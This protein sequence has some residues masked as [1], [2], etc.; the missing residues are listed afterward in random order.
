MDQPKATG[1]AK[2]Q[3][4]AGGAG[5]RCAFRFPRRRRILRTADFDRVMK[6]GV[7]MSDERLTV[8]AI[9]NGLGLTR[10]GLTVGRKHGPAVTRNRLKRI[11]REAFRLAQHDI[12]SG[13]DLVCTPRTGV[14]PGLDVCR[15]SLVRLAKRF[16]RHFEAEVSDSTD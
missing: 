1:S 15:K 2:P 13:F 8:W 11:L 5:P 9:P 6:T 7:R 10:L 4:A 16:G 3:P 12:P 14:E